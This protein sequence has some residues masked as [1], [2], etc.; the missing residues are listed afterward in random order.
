MNKDNLREL[1]KSNGVAEDKL[2]GVLDTIF[3]ENGKDIQAEKSKLEAK[4][5]ELTKA[6]ETI[7][8]LQAT[9]KKAEAEDIEGLKKSARE[10]EEKYNSDLEASKNQLLQVQRSYELKD[11][12]KTKG[13]KDPDYL[14]FKQGG[15]DKFAF[16]DNNKVIGLDDILKGYQENTPHLF[17]TKKEDIENSTMKSGG[18]HGNGGSSTAED[19]IINSAKAAAGIATE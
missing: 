8:G 2:N 13:V 12:L 9:I 1:L 6:N 14:I 16:D 10:W 15:V 3:A 5:E 11:S 7:E 17:E 18:E 4:V 19:K